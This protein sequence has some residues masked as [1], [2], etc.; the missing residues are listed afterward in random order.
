MLQGVCSGVKG[1]RE[2]GGGYKVAAL[3]WRKLGMMGCCAREGKDEERL[4]RKQR[5]GGRGQCGDGGSRSEC[6]PLHA[7]GKPSC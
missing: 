5:G 3:E 4:E 6:G 7:G 1:F 2:E